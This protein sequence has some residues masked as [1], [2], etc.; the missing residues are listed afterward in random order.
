MLN[1]MTWA[2]DAIIG[3]R[4]ATGRDAAKLP[5]K[6][7]VRK[8]LLALAQSADQIRA[9]IVAT[10]EGGAITGEERLREYLG[11]LYGDVNQYEGRPTDS[12]AQRADVLDRELGDV[13]KEF[14]TLTDQ[15]LP[16]INRDLARHKLG[17]IQVVSEEDWQKAHGG[18]GGSA[19]PMPGFFGRGL[20]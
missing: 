15:Q 10:K 6:D 13:V 9:K 17:A 16:A 12:Q 1:H 11:G 5:E 18:G 3:V 20:D 8:R 4:D 19:A 14:T 7:P 2:V